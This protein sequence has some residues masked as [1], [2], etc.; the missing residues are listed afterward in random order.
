[1]KG[2]DT[3]TNYHLI[4]LLFHLNFLLGESNK[5][6]MA[7][8][9]IFFKK[10]NVFFREKKRRIRFRH[11][12]ILVCLGIVVFLSFK[13]F[14]YL[15]NIS[16]TK[17]ELEEMKFQ[18]SLKNLPTWDLTDLYPSIDSEEVK[19]DLEL[20][21]TKAQNFEKKYNRKG[22]LHKIHG[23][24]F[25]R[26]VREYER[27]H[28]LRGK[29]GSYA[30]LTYAE[31]V[32][33]E[34]NVHFYQKMTEELADVSSH[35]LFFTL[36][37]NNLPTRNLARKY[38][39]SPSLK[40]YKQLIDDLRLLK[41]H[42]LSEDLEKLFLDKSVT[43]R[44]AWS[45]LFDE[46]MNN[47]IFEM[48]GKKYNSSQML[49]KISSKDEKIRRKAAKIF[50]EKLGDNIRLFAHVT[51]ILAKDKEINDKWRKFERAISSRNLTNLIE[52]EVV[53]ALSET[54]KKNYPAISHRYYKLKAKMMKK[55]KM[56]YADRNAPLPFD[57]DDKYNWEETRDIV[58]RAYADFSPAMAEVGQKFF[59]NNWIDVPTRHGKRGGAFAAPS[60]PS[61]HPYLL[62]NFQGKIR[63]VTTLAHELGHGIHQYLAGKEQGYLLS[64]TPLTL[65][66]TA[67][68]FGE[69]LTFR[70]LMTRE[71]DPEKRKALLANKI[72]D[73][74]NTVIRQIAFLEFEKRVHD[75]RKNGEIPTER[76]N[77]IWM[78]VQTESLGEDIFEFDEE[79]KYYWSYIPHFVHTPFYVYAYAFGECLVNSLY[80]VYLENPEGFEAKY[81][82]LLKAGGSKRYDELLKPFGLDPKD[83]EF[84]QKGL[85]MIIEMIDE[86]EGMI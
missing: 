8:R 69:R 74:I 17:Q 66:E 63:D 6:H 34:K 43:G 38:R 1:M 84:W 22:K 52:D 72:E 45:R 35:L 33:L 26:A 18:E 14:S 27:I 44:S 30:F 78:E 73:T 58:L 36:E 37:I 85:D 15:K 7:R 79:Y 19:N 29:L 57:N 53:D 76:L 64:D 13:G 16:K 20:L 10:D 24:V 28:E 40:K 50:G 11:V 81:I 67:S 51:N 54:V 39:E 68:V 5:N 48:D 23:T 12:F 3:S 56:H 47:M 21:K 71:Q 25:F 46:T 61:V 86:L 41:N 65:S 83:P 62:L 4:L 9:N 60:V 49:A 80:S 55:R 75:E 2:T 32:S 42:Q 77:E 31:N 59:D 70:S 82:E